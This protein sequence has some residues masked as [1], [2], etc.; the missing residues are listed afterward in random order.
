MYIGTRLAVLAL[1]FPG[2]ALVMAQDVSSPYD[3]IEGCDRENASRIRPDSGCGAPPSPTI[4]RSELE[5]SVTLQ[6]P[7]VSTRQ[8][9][10]GISIGYL[11]R[12]TTARVEGTLRNE[13]C[14][15]SSGSYV[16]VISTRGENGESNTEEFH[17]LWQRDDDQPVNFSDDFSIGENVDLVRVRAQRIQCSCDSPAEDQ[18]SA[19]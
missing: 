14:G 16:L 6:M 13:D 10:A 5:S 8:C 4:F 9:R 18:E 15:A 3:Q 12:N 2:P 7:Q 1:F 17:Q 19:E 11:Q